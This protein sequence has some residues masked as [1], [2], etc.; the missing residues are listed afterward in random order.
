VSGACQIA[1]FFSRQQLYSAFQL[2]TGGLAMR[3]LRTSQIDRLD[4]QAATALG[5]THC[6]LYRRL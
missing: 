4:D 6:T 1:G 3:N 5:D 2:I